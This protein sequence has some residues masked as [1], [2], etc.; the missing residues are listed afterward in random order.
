M[1]DEV[2]K[3]RLINTKERVKN[4]SCNIKNLMESDVKAIRSRYNGFYPGKLSPRIL[5]RWC[6]DD[7]YDL[8]VYISDKFG[9]ESEEARIVYHLENVD[10][11]ITDYYLLVME[12]ELEKCDEVLQDHYD[13]CLGVIELIDGIVRHV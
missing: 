4:L 11:V 8:E 9:A 12:G 5:D 6:E 10:K 1:D 7:L 13:G 2:I 3:M